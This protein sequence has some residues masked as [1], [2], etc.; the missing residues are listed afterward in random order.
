MCIRDSPRDVPAFR[1]FLRACDGAALLAQELNAHKEA[2]RDAALEEA[3]AVVTLER[4]SL[5]SELCR[6]CL[7]C[8]E[9]LAGVQPYFEHLWAVHG[10]NCGSIEDL[11]CIPHFL[12]AVERRQAGLQCLNCD[13]CFSDPGTLRTHMRK[14]KHFRIHPKNSSFDRFWPVSYTHLR[15]HETVLDLVCRLLLEKKKHKT[16]N[17]S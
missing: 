9:V 2:F 12:D 8:Q 17:D 15:A 5:R 3:L 16:T 7:F 11:V 10:L 1:A 6:R 4:Q 14:K 13:K